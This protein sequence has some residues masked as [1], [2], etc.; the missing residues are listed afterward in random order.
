MSRS[1]APSPNGFAGKPLS[2]EAQL[3]QHV[4]E[5]EAG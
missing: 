5:L 4:D 1:V 2:R 3:Q